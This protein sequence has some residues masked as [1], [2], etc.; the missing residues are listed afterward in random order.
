MASQKR[1]FKK[2]KHSPYLIVFVCSVTL[3]VQ[4]MLMADEKAVLRAKKI[5]KVARDI[6]NPFVS[7]DRLMREIKA[8][9][10]VDFPGATGTSSGRRGPTNGRSVRVKSQKSAR[11]KALREARP[12]VP[13]VHAAPPGFVYVETVDVRRSDKATYQLR[14]FP[15]SHPVIHN[16]TG[17]FVRIS[18]SANDVLA[19]MILIVTDPIPSDLSTWMDRGEVVLVRKEGRQGLVFFQRDTYYYT[20]KGGTPYFA[21][22]VIADDGYLSLAEQP[23]YCFFVEDWDTGSETAAYGMACREIR[24][25]RISFY[26]RK[27]EK[28]LAAERAIAAGYELLIKGQV[29]SDISERVISVGNMEPVVIVHAGFVPSEGGS[30][31]LARS[32]DKSR[33]PQA[34]DQKFI[35]SHS[36]PR[37][38]EQA[39]EVEVDGVTYRLQ[40][41]FWKLY[42]KEQGNRR[43]YLSYELYR[44][45]RQEGEIQLAEQIVGTW[46]TGRGETT[47]FSRDGTFVIEFRPFLQGQRASRTTGTYRIEGQ[48]IKMGEYG[49]LKNSDGEERNEQVYDWYVVRVDDNEVKC[50]HG[51]R[52]SVYS[53]ERDRVYPRIR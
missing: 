23:E 35:E 10:E 43:A 18:Q 17:S 13:T 36:A 26:A 30:V 39:I 12:S 38:Q 9:I 40:V 37:G 48:W 11:I 15:Y 6:F 31:W 45:K 28:W 50:H 49:R 8:A 41:T 44:R 33:I 3:I 47:T 29:T 19:K 7:N 25:M 16:L 5:N 24:R 2:V 4:S 1:K 32:S 51:L 14:W 52:G 22:P 42:G 53:T 20:K 21:T 46:R 34:I 27:P